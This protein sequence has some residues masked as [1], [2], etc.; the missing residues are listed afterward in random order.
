MARKRILIV[1]PKTTMHGFLRRVSSQMLLWGLEQAGVDWEMHNPWREPPPLSRFHAALCWSRGHRR[2]NFIYYAR[3]FEKLCA[4]EGLP[5]INSIR[6]CSDNHSTSL[7]RWKQHGIPCAEFTRFRYVH[8]IHLDYPLILR[9]D[10]VHQGKQTFLV[11]SREEAE[12]A[13]AEQERASFEERPPKEAA[14]PL[15]L[16]IRYVDTRYPDGLY[17]KRRCY[18]VGDWLVPRQAAATRHWLVNLG[19]C[20]VREEAIEEDRAFRRNGELNADLVRNAGLLTGSEISAVDY[21]VRP[22]GR[23]IFWETNRHFSMTGDPDY[24]SAKLD[25]ATG[26]TAKERREDD[27]ALGNALASLVCSRVRD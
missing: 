21:T 15:N 1:T 22:D 11:T 6:G 25:A 20:E 18:V 10:N 23:Y 24:Q 26:R 3:I 8:Q 7:S 4:T 9:V 12:R 14:L 17:R 5:V 13:A 16:A 27:E 2:K 19:N